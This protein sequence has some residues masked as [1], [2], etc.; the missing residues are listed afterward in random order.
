MPNSLKLSLL[1]LVV[2]LGACSSAPVHYHTLMPPHAGGTHQ[3][4]G[5]EIQIERL[6]VPA[7]VDRTQLVIRQGNSGLAILEFE[8]WGASLAEEFQ[9]A[10]QDQLDGG[11]QR[12]SSVRVEVQ[13][14]DSLPGQY[15]LLE[16][17]WRLRSIGAGNSVAETTCR[18]TL[19][20]PS[21]AS[22]D[23]L[24]AAHQ[25]NVKRL[26]DT[27]NQASRTSGTCPAVR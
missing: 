4:S 17:K 19:Q 6:T 25:N 2:V 14:F 3:V 22:I 20:T 16:A 26:A 27:I 5:E 11:A 1:S 15:A 13:R 24:V 7:Q 21:G 9:G 10:L 8:W 12:R 18:T 23:E